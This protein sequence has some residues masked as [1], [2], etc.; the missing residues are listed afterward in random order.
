MIHITGYT[1]PALE[2]SEPSMS[3]YVRELQRLGY[4]DHC[5]DFYDKVKLSQ[6]DKL[7]KDSFCSLL[8]KEA[9]TR[10]IMKRYQE[11]KNEIQA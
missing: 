2:T 7:I 5:K 3:H 8:M 6:V 4:Q 9:V 11:L 10:L 1:W